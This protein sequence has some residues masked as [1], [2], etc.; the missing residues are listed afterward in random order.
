MTE[1]DHTPAW[2]SKR[3]F[4]GLEL[5][6]SC[7]GALSAIKNPQLTGLRWLPEEQFHLTLSFLGQVETSAEDQLRKALGKVRIAPFFLPLRGTGLFDTGR[8]ASVIWVGVG[9]GHPHLFALH[10]RIQD[11]ILAAGLEPSLQAFHPHVT[12]GR[13][14]GI[15]REALKPLIRLHAETEFGLIRVTSFALF[16][17][18]LTAEGA[19]H[20]VEIRWDL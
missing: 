17:S 9:Q 19:I 20:K 2:P 8:R 4:V 3:L 1:S 12:I 7:R 10:R 6:A 11:A 5:P 15:S 14:N 16:S 13:A 18:V